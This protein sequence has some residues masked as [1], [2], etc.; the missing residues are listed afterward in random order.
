MGFHRSDS[1]TPK[2]NG[3]FLVV[4]RLIFLGGEVGGGG[5]GDQNTRNAF[6]KVVFLFVLAKKS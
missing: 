4:G 5:E 2:K 1:W 6:E 3:S